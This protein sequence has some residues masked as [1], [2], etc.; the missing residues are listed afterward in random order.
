MVHIYVS[1]YVELDW[2]ICVLPS[3]LSLLPHVDV[4]ADDKNKENGA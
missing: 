4:D 2:L 1:I 3:L